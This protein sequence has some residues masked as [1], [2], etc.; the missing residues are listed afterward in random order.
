MSYEITGTVKAILEA[1]T[2]DS[3]FSV[4]EF[5]VTIEDG[6]Y[7]QH[8]KL[9]FVNDKVALLDDVNEGDTVTVDFFINGRESNG[10][11]W[12]SLTAWRITAENKSENQEPQPEPPHENEEEDDIPF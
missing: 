6:K 7:P 3:G 8:I 4:R 11:Y 5:V 9:Q 10:N 2:F 1:K 12:N